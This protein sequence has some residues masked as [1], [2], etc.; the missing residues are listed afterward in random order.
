MWQRVLLMI[1]VVVVLMLVVIVY[2]MNAYKT[3][4]PAYRIVESHG[5]I[6][7]REY[8]PLLVA[9]VRVKGERYRAINDGF[10]LL[11]D[12]IFGNN[13]ANT[14]IAMTAPVLQQGTQ[15]A[16][17]APVLQQQ[18]GKEWVVRFVMPSTYTQET[19]PIPV[20]PL[21][22]IISLPAL[23]YVV[24]KFTGWNSDGN[25]TKHLEVLQAYAASHQL[26]VTGDPVM[27][28]YN[29]PWILPFLRRNEIL[30][31]LK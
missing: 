14:K 3:P 31:E 10:R 23:K 15:I 27:A 11:A 22:K 13:K 9:E 24:I 17:T 16:M 8:P 12:Y 28:F 18:E 5:D 2:Q 7:I 19:L 6:E 20:N 30:L 4:E 21:V 25:L 29:P 1:V 26:A